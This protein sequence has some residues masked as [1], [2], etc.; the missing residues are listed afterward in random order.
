MLPDPLLL[1]GCPVSVP[2]PF[3]FP[4]VVVAVVVDRAA[5]TMINFLEFVGTRFWLT[6][7][8]PPPTLCSLSNLFGI[9]TDR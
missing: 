4:I 9:L 8:P 2:D 5:G 6:P 3:A 1:A 7:P